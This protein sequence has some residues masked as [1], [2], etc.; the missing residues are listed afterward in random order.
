VIA[1]KK[2]LYRVAL[3]VQAKRRLADVT[4]TKAGSVFTG[5]MVRGI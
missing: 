1:A 3:Y 4:I 2:Q 5:L